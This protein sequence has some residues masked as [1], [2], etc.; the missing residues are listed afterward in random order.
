MSHIKKLQE[1]NSEALGYGGNISPP[2]I[3]AATAKQLAEQN[4]KINTWIDFV[5]RYT[6]WTREMSWAAIQQWYMHN[7]NLNLDY[8]MDYL[9]GK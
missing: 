8:I 4:E 2:I 6:G 5:M 9:G 1:S 3:G 7:P